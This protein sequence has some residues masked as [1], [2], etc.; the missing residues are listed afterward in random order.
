MIIKEIGGD[1][2][3]EFQ[4]GNIDILVHGCNCFHTMGAGIAGQIARKY[5][6]V[7]EEDARL[8]LEGSIFKLGNYIAVEIGNQEIINAYTQYEPGPNFEYA[9]L[10]KV[11]TS[12]NTDYKDKGMFFGFPLIGCGI[13]AGNWE[14]VKRIINACT[15]DL[16]VIIVHYDSGIK[17]MGQTEIDFKPQTT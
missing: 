14:L 12:L 11:L 8:T 9:A 17:D 15:P 4:K 6:Q 7:A 16:K 3:D 10:I 2:L 13:G 1:L 5:S